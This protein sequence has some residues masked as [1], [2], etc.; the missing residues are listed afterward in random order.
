MSDLIRAQND[1]HAVQCLK[2]LVDGWQGLLPHCDG[3][4]ATKVIIT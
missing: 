3:R 2:L 4:L 1:D